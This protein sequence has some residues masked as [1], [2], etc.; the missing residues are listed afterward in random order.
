[1]GYVIFSILFWLFLTA[2]SIIIFAGALILWLFTFPFDRRGWLQHRYSCFWGWIYMWLNPFWDLQIEGRGKIDHSHVYVAVSNH[3]SMLD[4][5]VIHSLFFHFKWVSKKENLYLPFI[6]WNML[7]NRYVVI[8]RASR[9]SFIRMMRDCKNHIKQGSSIMIFPEGARSFDGKLR[10][11][12]DGAF[13]LAQQM[14]TPILPI[15]LD[16][17]WKA[18]EG[19]S[20]V[21]RRRT[22]LTVKVLDPIMPDE[23]SGMEPHEMAVKV[24]EIMKS[25]LDEMRQSQA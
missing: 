9:K 21:I 2:T 24:R 4:I 12:K 10:N 14:K 6:G 13:R 18:I 11:F 16:G 8:D 15:V 25:A 1:M 22:R 3:Q 20:L 19:K 23:F 7:L 17:T 5:L